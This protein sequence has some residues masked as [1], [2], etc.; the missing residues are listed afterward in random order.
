MYKHLLCSRYLTTRYIALFSVVSVMLGVTTMIV[1]NSVMGGFRQRMLERLHGILSDVIVESTTMDGF[2]HPDEIMSRINA[3]VGDKIEAMTPAIEVFGMLHFQNNGLGQTFTRPVRLVGV[4]PKGRAAVGEFGDHLLNADN[5]KD[6]SFELRADGKEWREKNADL[7]DPKFG[8]PKAGSIIGYQIATFRGSNMFEDQFLIRPGQEVVITTVTAGRKPEPVSDR[9]VV[10][11]H[12]RSDMSEY[13]SNYVFMPLKE[14]QER[15]RMGDAVTAIQIK[16]KD[17]ADSP[18]VVGALRAALPPTFFHVQTW[19][20]KQGPLLQAVKVE[21]AILNIILFF[22][23][24]VAGFGILAIF[25][26]IVYEK[27]RDIGILKALGASNVGVMNIFL[28]YGFILGLVGSVFGVI[29]GV[30]IT[31]NINEIEETIYKW[32]GL[33]LF[34]PDIYYFKE[35]PAQLD[36]MTVVWIVAGALFIAAAASV[37]PAIRASKL[38]PVEALRYE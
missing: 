2:R 15:R 38:R 28:G 9:L 18:A 36:P 16:L 5:S 23:I 13:D 12:F 35:I 37:L 26:M 14:L 1:V 34:P 24:A 19:E 4:D 3:A 6:P 30:S 8:V 11:D 33:E 31:L 22:I 21:A 20:D 29:L 32:T 25:Y 7:F 10:V 27:T 17:E